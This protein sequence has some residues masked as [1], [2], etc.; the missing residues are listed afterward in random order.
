CRLAIITMQAMPNASCIHRKP[1]DGAMTARASVAISVPSCASSNRAMQPVRGR[2]YPPTPRRRSESTARWLTFPEPSHIGQSSQVFSRKWQAGKA[3]ATVGPRCP[4][5]TERASLWCCPS[6]DTQGH[7]DMQGC[8]TP[9]ATA[10]TRRIA[11]GL[12]LIALALSNA[13]AA[14]DKP[15]AIPA[16]PPAHVETRHTITL[17]S[18]SLDYRAIA[19]TIS[20][21]DQK[22]RPN[23]SV[24]TIAYLA[25][26]SA[27]P[28]RAA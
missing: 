14:D 4:G 25:E 9:A 20:L 11:A 27:G 22:G 23:A 2:R 28:A 6:S 7:R 15:P 26:P 12:L 24:Y 1:D 17:N 5:Q 16:E 3:S 18:H 10:I 8:R 21:T 19:E 13:R